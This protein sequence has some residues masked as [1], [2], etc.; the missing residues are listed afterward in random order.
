MSL[1]EYM[2]LCLG[3]PE[4][5]YYMTRDPFGEAGD[6]TTAPEISQMFGEVIGAWLADSWVKIGAPKRVYFVGM[7]A[8]ARN[9]NEQMSYGRLRELRNFMKL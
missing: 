2:G 3:H 6:F 1:A 9:I 8:G 4:Y 5:G 7:W